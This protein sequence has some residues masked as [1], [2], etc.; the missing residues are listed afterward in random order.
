MADQHLRTVLHHLHRRAEARAAGAL[1]DGELLDRF[2]A[3]GDQAAFTALV[4]RHGPMVLGLCRRVLGDAH[5]AEDACQAAFLVL[6]RKA[7]SIRKKDTLASWLHGV[8]YHVASNLRRGRAR[9]RAHQGP[10]RDAIQADPAGE[11]TWR[12]VR[13]ALDEEL[14]RLP[15]RYRVPLV[16]C[17]LEG[18]TRDEAAQVLGWSEGA[19]RGRLERGREVLRA[20]LIR[21]GFGLS[22]ALL[23]GALGR[24]AVSASLPPTLVGPTVRAAS[25]FAVGRAAAGSVPAEV[26]SLA[27]GVL[28]AMFL[29]KLRAGA[30]VLLVLGLVTLGGALLALGPSRAEGDGSGRPAGDHAPPAQ[31][32]AARA[33][34]VV[35]LD[36]QGQPLADANVHAGVWTDEKGFKANRDYKTDAAGAAQVELP[37]SFTILRLWARKRPF[38]TMFAGWE[39]N[40]LASGKRVP[41]EYTFRLESAVTAGGRVV[42]EQGKPVAGAKVEVQMSGD[43]KPANGDGRAGYDIWLSEGSDAATTDA[44]GRWRIDNVPNHPRAELSLQVSHPDYVSDEVW[45][46][47]QKAAGVTTAMLRQGTATLTLKGGVIVRGRVTDPS[48]RPIKEAIVVYRDDPYLTPSELATD[49]DGR[50][51]LP[52]LAPGQTTLTVVAPGW[53]P[54]LRKVN[55]RAGL[56]PQDFEMQP[57]KPIRLR[58]V[59]GAGKPVPRAAVNITGWKGSKSLYS[60]YNL[61]N[62]PKMPDT[63]IQRQADADG[64]WEWASA[65][66][67]PVKLQIWS[68]GF[69]AS[70]L[71]VAGGAPERTV[72]LKAEHRVTGRVTDAATGKPIPAFTVIP[73]DVFRKDFLGAERG[74]AVAGKDGRLDFLADRTDI[75]LRLRLEAEGYRSQDG[76]EFRVGED[77]ARTQDFR[78]RPSEPV[79]GVVLDAGG[80]PAANAEVLLATPTEQASFQSDWGNHKTTTDAAGRFAFPDPGE[81]FAVIARADAGFAQAE[82]PADRHDAGTLRLRPWA[83]VRG[84]FRDGGRPVRGATVLLQPVHLDTL[85]GPRIDDIIQTVTGPD[86]RFELPRVAP[87]PV[88]VRVYLGPWKDEGFRSG[89]GVPLDLR[90]G[91]RAEV[92]LGGAGAVVT[93]KVKLTGKVPADLDCTY[94]LNYLVRREPGI[95]PPPPLARLG[96]DVRTGWRDSWNKT[97]EGRAY[98]STLR[99]WFV[100]LAPDGTFRVSGVPAGE[101]DLAVEV[102]AK[103]SGCLVDPLAHKVVPVTVTAADA[104]RGELALP[105]VA[106]EVAPVPAVG[107][108]PALTFHRAD[109]TAGTL[110]DCRG[111]YT[112]VHFWASWCVTCKRQLP[113]LRRLEERFAA[114]GLATLGLALDEDEAAWQAALKRLDL[115]GPQG[116]LTDEE[117]GVSSVPAYW[118]LDPAGKIVSKADD[119]EE[120]VAPLAERLK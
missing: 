72:T 64:V 44:D 51:R 18:R 4:E 30:A 114:R 93:G 107:D 100:K 47:G 26:A 68:K 35:V 111:R 88:C 83:S 87:V 110:A 16:L 61:P 76:P 56:P 102:Y 45:R 67:D 9:R 19:F 59:D 96:F 14:A 29:N 94:S 95:E 53:A 109:G 8:A 92:D 2:A 69:A 32:A 103:P 13:A 116:R 40:E 54:Q 106:A 28:Q 15:E 113:A 52:A 22:A 84:Q 75:A 21:R 80:R 79:A 3:H 23:A 43:A 55:L 33:L 77:A 12:E 11:V 27:E 39:Q 5:D 48:G 46:E 49:A 65:P 117:A 120:L 20:R 90:P 86:G 10:H 62:H 70:E 104:A 101:Y 66:D 82:F 24:E 78:L 74:N 115:P 6:A 63:G 1:P 73:V 71:E 41:A 99:H 85:D 50:F 98:L 91:Q 7:A 36:P 118:L 60:S 38:V 112:V 108:T 97:A 89:P 42:D 34:R 17:Y 105:E 81:P 31:P 58:V 57:G 119:P 37:R 25:G